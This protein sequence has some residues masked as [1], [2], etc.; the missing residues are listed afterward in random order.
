MFFCLTFILYVIF[1]FSLFFYPMPN[2]FYFY[3]LAGATYCIESM[4]WA[5]MGVRQQHSSSP[6]CTSPWGFGFPRGEGWVF[7][8]KEKPEFSLA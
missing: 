4:V 7:A 5:W 8:R 6:A 2:K 3:L 1:F